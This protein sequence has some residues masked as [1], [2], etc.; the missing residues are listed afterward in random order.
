MAD[1]TAVQLLRNNGAA[2]LKTAGAVSQTMVYNR[3]DEAIFL[4]VENGDAAVDCGIKVAASGQM[5]G[6]TDLDVDVA[7]GEFAIIGPLE[8]S[9]FKDPA[10]GK[11][12]FEILDTDDTVYSGTVASVLVT[13]VNLPLSLTD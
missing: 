10:T 11:V 8:S 12:T 13:Q 9:R 6:G 3:R 5:A 2:W 4:L 7:F 1:L